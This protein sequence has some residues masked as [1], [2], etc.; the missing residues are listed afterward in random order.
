[1]ITPLL[2]PVNTPYRYGVRVYLTI[3]KIAVI[4]WMMWGVNE[5]LRN[6]NRISNGVLWLSILLILMGLRPPFARGILQR[7]R[8]E[9][10]SR[11]LTLPQIVAAIEKRQQEL[12]AAAALTVDWVFNEW[13]EIASADPSEIIYARLE[14]CRHCHGVEHRYQ[15][16]EFEYAQAVDLALAHR[17]GPNMR[18]AMPGGSGAGWARGLRLLAA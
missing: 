18:S 8:L 1:M 11:L 15:W 4:L 13:R 2:Y 10:S 17:C 3:D 12:A 14:C 6:S 5:Q 7:L 9:I 16:T